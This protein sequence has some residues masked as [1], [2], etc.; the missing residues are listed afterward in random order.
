[1]IHQQNS[2]TLFYD[3]KG[4]GKKALLLF[5][6]FGQDHTAFNPL[7][8][9]LMNEYV[10]YSFDLYFHGRSTWAKEEEPL[11]KQEWKNTVDTFLRETAIEEFSLLGFSLGGKFALA[12]LEAFP[13]KTKGIFLVAPDGIQTSFWYSLATYPPLFRKLFKSMILHPDRFFSIARILNGSGLLDKGVLRFAEHQM[14][15]E[16]KRARVYFS[17]VVFRH[18]SFEMKKIAELIHTHE[19]SLTILVGKY[20]KVIQPKRMTRLLKHLKHYTLEVTEAGHNHLIN[21]T[22][23]ESL[24]LSVKPND[25]RR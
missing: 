7:I 4:T 2:S 18:L 3:R 19:V 25:T 8:E 10:C 16:E 21:S 17:W 9:S 20:D 23:L 14:N 15:S 12:T 11:E 13:E 22:I 1:M 5:H 24:L 6:G